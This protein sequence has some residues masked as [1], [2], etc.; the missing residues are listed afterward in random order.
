MTYRDDEH[1]APSPLFVGDEDRNHFVPIED[2]VGPNAGEVVAERTGVG[3]RQDE[4]HGLSQYLLTV[5]RVG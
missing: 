4:R 5:A 2:G 3:R 1:M